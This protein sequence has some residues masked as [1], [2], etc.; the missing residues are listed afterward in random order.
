[1]ATP[2]AVLQFLRHAQARGENTALIALTGVEGG[3][4]RGIGTLMGVTAAGAWL[5]S[6]S[7]G[8]VESALVGEAQRVIAAGRAE[9][10]RLGAGSPLIDIRLPC[11]SGIDL[12]LIPDPNAAAIARA[13]DGAEVREAV[14]LQLGRDGSLA[15]TPQYMTSGWHDDSFHLR[16][17]PPLR[18]VIAGHGEET[19]AL[20]ALAHSWGAELLVL[21]PDERTAAACGADA[22]LLKTPGAHP[23]LRLDRWS[24]LVMLFHDH[25]WETALLAQ[26]LGQE[27]LFIGAMGSKRTHGNRLAA[28]AAAGVSA[29]LAARIKGPIG[30]IPAARD[31][32]TLALS[33]LSEVVAAWQA[34]GG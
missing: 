16:L 10:L 22:V 23:A 4:A 7:G 26:A 29:Q 19:T 27:A 3:A 17:D 30:L 20:A 32:R 18:L 34:R 24:A 2:H 5:G 13:C 9:E 28:L 6:L 12:L 31:P 11:G 21:T 33:V 8:C 1:M 25:D 14:C 15:V